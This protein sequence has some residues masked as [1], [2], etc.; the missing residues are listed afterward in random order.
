[1]PAEFG[2]KEKDGM[3]EIVKIRGIKPIKHL[4]R[5]YKEG[6]PRMFAFDESRGIAIISGPRNGMSFRVG[7]KF[8]PE[9][10][11]IMLEQ[12][13]SAGHRLYK[14]NHNQSVDGIRFVEI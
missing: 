13:K 8:T 3:V 11:N 6:Y 4:P 7:T 10:F 1:M 14:I 2:I 12:A 5:L 9:Q